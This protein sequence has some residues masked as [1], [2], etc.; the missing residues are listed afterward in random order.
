MQHC[1][2][3]SKHAYGRTHGCHILS[4]GLLQVQQLKLKASIVD[5]ADLPFM[6]T[7]GE[8]QLQLELLLLL[9]CT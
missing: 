1:S 4:A 2:S 3:V 5:A 8:Q 9:A 7:S 6:C